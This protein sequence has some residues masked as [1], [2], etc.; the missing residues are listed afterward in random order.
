MKIHL[1][2]LRPQDSYYV[3]VSRLGC[4]ESGIRRPAELRELRGDGG[5]TY[6]P[7]ENWVDIRLE[8]EVSRRSG[9][10]VVRGED[11]RGEQLRR[12]RAQERSLDTE[13]RVVEGGVAV[14]VLAGAYTIWRE[15]G[16]LETGPT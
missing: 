2:R 9:P 3:S 11:D 5:V 7:H 12:G 1:G 4:F 6:T 15:E 14:E 13:A 10:R 16:R 8:D